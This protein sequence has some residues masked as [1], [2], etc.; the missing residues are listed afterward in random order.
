MR[1][2]RFSATCLTALVA[3]FSSGTATGTA[4]VATG[5]T[6]GIAAGI[7]AGVTVCLTACGRS[8]GG[9]EENSVLE[10][11]RTAI[12]IGEGESFRL[13]ATLKPITDKATPVS[14]RSADVSIAR[15]E[16]GLVT[17]VKAG[18]T[19]V[20]AQTHEKTVSCKVTVKKREK[21]EKGGG[22]KKTVVQSI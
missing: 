9:A 3:L 18:E 14:W 4:G 17:G 20:T 15:V 8:D 19:F 16:N 1:G 22:N 12:E 7:A 21:G 2:K 6:A 10:L 13:T 5:A 11:S